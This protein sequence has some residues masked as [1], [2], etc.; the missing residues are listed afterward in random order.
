MM[1]P[2]PW[3]R[4]PLRDTNLFNQREPVSMELKP[5]NPGITSPYE[6]SAGHESDMAAGDSTRLAYHVHDPQTF[7]PN[8]RSA[9][10]SNVSEHHHVP[11]SHGASAVVSEI[12]S[13]KT[14]ME[15][16]AKKERLQSLQGIHLGED[17]VDPSRL[18]GMHVDSQPRAQLPA[19]HADSVRLNSATSTA[20]GNEKSSSSRKG[21]LRWL[22]C[23]GGE[24]RSN[25]SVEEEWT[26]ATTREHE[27][28]R[29]VLD[30]RHSVDELQHRLQQAEERF[31]AVQEDKSELERRMWSLRGEILKQVEQQV[32]SE[33]VRRERFEEL[34]KE[35][36]T[37]VEKVAR[38][39]DELKST[40]SIRSDLA[41]EKGKVQA[42]Q[43][44][45][46]AANEE[47]AVLK[48]SWRDGESGREGQSSKYESLPSL[49]KGRLL[50]VDRRRLASR[51]RGDDL[52]LVSSPRYN[53]A[54]K[55]SRSCSSTP[56][57]MQFD[58][59]EHCGYRGCNNRVE[60]RGDH[61][62]VHC[63]L[64]PAEPP[65]PAEVESMQPEEGNKQPSE[66]EAEVIP[67]FQIDEEEVSFHD[68]LVCEIPELQVDELLVD[69]SLGG[70]PPP[71][72]EPTEVSMRSDR[73][74][75]SLL[76]EEPAERREG[77]SE[78][79]D[80]AESPARGRIID[81]FTPEELEAN[82]EA[83]NRNFDVHNYANLPSS[84]C[85]SLR[86]NLPAAPPLQDES[87][88]PMSS[89]ASELHGML[90]SGHLFPQRAHGS[91][92]PAMS[93]EW[94]NE[95]M[96]PPS[97]FFLGS[98]SR[99]GGCGRAPSYVLGGATSHPVSFVR[100]AKV[101]QVGG[102]GEEREH[103]G[104]I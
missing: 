35:H 67:D 79:E 9:T 83:A 72:L 55:H 104:Y 34:E 25:L 73:S 82:L 31:A 4:H 69:V 75:S 44:Q 43:S 103:I 19:G 26:R 65:Q 61:H 30:L 51:T 74:R 93:N 101:K 54:A 46:S 27:E 37:V 84:G 56:R 97:S 58:V 80:K 52:F 86:W 23:F 63:P 14:C 6:I 99:P 36:Q 81:L 77:R 47:I 90:L 15:P 50:P 102:W 22:K 60:Q 76:V 16:W 98:D 94:I 53:I 87:I 3:P 100:G 91:Q 45:L 92:Q 24:R 5:L 28:S 70:S 13:E 10:T 29:H 71:A 85:T 40:E 66:Q 68:V 11:S 39:V 8:K 33:F 1:A 96:V 20:A 88:N 78:R 95:S 42:L 12:S 17:N 32:V 62:A 57:V 7:S 2:Q 89:P 59:C 18:D 64:R 48:K 49:S 21:V 41:Q 38:M